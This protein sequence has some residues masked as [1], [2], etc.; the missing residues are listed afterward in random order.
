MAMP[1]SQSFV[2]PDEYL[3]L[4]RADEHRHEY[5]GGRIYAMTGASR[6]H[7]VIATNTSRALGNQLSARPCETYQSDMRVKVSDTGM[8][9]YPDVVVACGT[10][11]FEDTHVDTLLN[12]TVIIEVLSPSTEAYDR[13]DKFAH[14]R[15]LASL[16]EYVLIAQDRVHAEHYARQGDRGEQ[17][18]LTEL[19]APS[20]SSGQALDVTLPLVSLGCT[21]ALADIY[22]RVLPAP[23]A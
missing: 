14:Y 19:A 1:A 13:G 4:E 2:S 16:R 3:A 8:Y 15:R 7:N 20:T 10:P 11:A 18:L 17:W 9:A 23:R 22:D 6:A 21:L 12:P 5:V